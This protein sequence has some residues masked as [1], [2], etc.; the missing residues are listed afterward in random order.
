[1][2]VSIGVRFSIIFSIWVLSLK[3]MAES[4][5]YVR[6]SHYFGEAPSAPK[7]SDY[8]TLGTDL[9]LDA[10]SSN[11]QLRLNPV[12]EDS[13]NARNELYFGIPEAFVQT[14]PV[15]TGMQLTVGRQKR[16]W[17]RLDEEFNLGIWQPQLRWDY[18]EP[19]PQGLTGFFLDV[20]ATKNLNFVF[21]TSPVFLPDQGPNYQLK[22][23]EFTSGN[24]WFREPQS[25]ISL[26]SDTKFAK[27]SP[28]YFE[29]DRPE[30]EKIVLNS[31]FGLGAEYVSDGPFWVSAN[32]AY[33]PRNQL[34]LGVECANCALLT[35]PALE[36]TAVIHPTVIK[37]HVVTFESGLKG[38]DDNAW[39]SLTGDFPGRSD[40]PSDYEESPLSSVLI[41][42][43]AVEH[44]M[45]SIL[46]FASWLKLGY[47]QSYAL[48]TERRKGLT[49]STDVQS[50]LDRF[51]FEK[52]AMIEGRIV[53]LDR[54][55]LKIDM[56]HRYHYST[57]ERGGWLA[58]RLNFAQGA[59]LYTVGLDVLGSEVSDG[60][61]NA[62]MF[63]QY[64]SNDR[65]YGGLGY[66]F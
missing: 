5:V 3:V 36:V 62:G 12:I 54:P 10:K 28:L 60:S 8:I 46:G 63:T 13:V 38:E 61:N 53:L 55:R 19:K 2:R 11:Y 14:T 1:M 26:F 16:R 22:N 44:N 20:K 33:K 23:G 59:W 50:S 6:P 27:D 34:H 56:T 17:S 24:R 65:V 30:T 29:I 25:R 7:H 48:K 66:V 21:F 64:R 57:P 52:L 42:G 49:E 41:F 35:S 31:S 39:I 18:L 15:E 45:A 58:S 43:G 51:A 37:D 4:A 9:K 32:Y 47:L 40:F